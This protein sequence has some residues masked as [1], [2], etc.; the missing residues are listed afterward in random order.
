MRPTPCRRS[1]LRRNYTRR[2]PGVRGGRRPTRRRPRRGRHETRSLMRP[3]SSMMDFRD[4]SVSGAGRIAAGP[5]GSARA[6]A[7]SSASS[8]Q[9]A[10]LA[11]A[12]IASVRPRTRSRSHQTTLAH[13][14]APADLAGVD[15]NGDPAFADLPEETARLRR[16]HRAVVVQVALQETAAHVVVQAIELTHQRRLST[17]WLRPDLQ[18]TD[19]LDCL[20]DGF[21]LAGDVSRWRCR[22]TRETDASRARRP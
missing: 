12:C 9:R 20:G 7:S 13:A 21:T 19:D 15:G 3:S 5:A 16:A 2:R 17:S 22:P 18:G 10:S 6:S 8:S 4:S 14:P 1:S 11:A